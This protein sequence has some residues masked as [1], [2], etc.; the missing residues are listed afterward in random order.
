MTEESKAMTTAQPSQLT[1]MDIIDRM[2]ERGVDIEQLKEAMALQE[3]HEAREARKTYNAAINAF[4]A[5]CPEIAKTGK[6][7]RY[8]FP[9]FE[10]IMRTIKP[11]LV[12]HGLSVTFDTKTHEHGIEAICTVAHVD[13]HS[14]QSSFSAPIDAKMVANATQKMGSANSYAKRYALLNALN[15]STVDPDDD[16]GALNAEP[17]TDEQVIEINEYIEALGVDVPAFLKHFGVKAV[18]DLNSRQYPKVIQMM[19]QKEAQR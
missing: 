19:K 11:Y 1:P 14:V 7:D 3:R 16:G 10:I 9:K 15:L 18:E 13:G 2:S 8:R 17:I 12:K 4:Q 5:E 6:T